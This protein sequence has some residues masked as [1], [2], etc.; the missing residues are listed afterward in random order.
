MNALNHALKLRSTVI[1]GP[2][3]RWGRAFLVALMVKNQP[4]MQET[5]VQSLGQGRP[6]EKGMANH[7]SIPAWRIPWTEKT[8]GLQSWGWKELDTTEVTTSSLF[9]DEETETYREEVVTAR[10]KVRSEQT[11]TQAFTIHRLPQITLWKCQCPH[12]LIGGQQAQG[13]LSHH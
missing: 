13:S 4:A 1:L 3:Y 7:S 11:Q 6:L 2:F 10:I 8:D 5:K 12:W 9:T